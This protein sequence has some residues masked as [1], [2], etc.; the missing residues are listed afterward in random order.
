[1]RRNGKKEML[2]TCG[3]IKQTVTNQYFS[4]IPLSGKIKTMKQQI[5]I[6][7]ALT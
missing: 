6:K 4:D 1:M 3:N 2:R 7:L 5:S